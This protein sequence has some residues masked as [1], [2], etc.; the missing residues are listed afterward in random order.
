MPLLAELE[1]RVLLGVLRNEDEAVAVRVHGEIETRT[2]HKTS[3]GSIYITLD[4]LEKKGLL[5][6]RLGEPTALQGAARR[7]GVFGSGMAR[8]SG[9][10]TAMRLPSRTAR[11]A[12]VHRPPIS[13]SP[14]RFTTASER[15]IASTNPSGA[16]SA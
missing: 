5:R 15:S 10:V 16:V 8:T 12:A 13:G 7:G 2:G 9:S 3:L 4:R 14:A 1:L 11:R 6:S